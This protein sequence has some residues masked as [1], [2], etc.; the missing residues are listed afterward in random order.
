MVTWWCWWC[1]WWPQACTE[2]LEYRRKLHRYSNE[3]DLV[4][5]LA[6]V[7]VKGG[8]LDIDKQRRELLDVYRVFLEESLE[9]KR[10]YI[11]EHGASILVMG[12][13]W[14]GRFDELNDICK[15]HYLPRTPS[16]ST[17]EIIEKIAGPG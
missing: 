2:L 3:E 13:D 17:T 11:V 16:V 15:V 12:D 7:S 10:D 14:E 1:W 8:S 4:P 6:Q 5:G 9:R